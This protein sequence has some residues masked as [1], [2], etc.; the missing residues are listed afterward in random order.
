VILTAAAVAVPE[1][2]LSPGWVQVDGAAIA[3]VGAGPPPGRPDR[4]FTGTLAPGLVDIHVHGGGGQ[5]FMTGTQEAA[6]TV[7]A[8]HRRHGTTSMMASLV[9]DTIDELERIVTSLVPL[10]QA[11]ELLGIHLEGPWLSSAHCGAHDPSRIALPDRGDIDRLLDAGEGTIRMVTIAPEL[12]GG[13]AA[14]RHLAARGVT[15]ALGHS[16]ATFDQAWESFDAGVS[17]GTHVFNAMRRLHHRDPA[18]VLAIVQAKEVYAEL[19]ADGIHVHPALLCTVASAKPR[20]TV[21]VSDAMGAAGAADGR[22]VLGPTEVEVRDGVARLLDGGAIAGSTL[23]L[24]RAVSYCTR[25]AGIPLHAALHAAT[26]A[27]ASALDE[28]AVGALLPG[29]RADLLALT[30]TLEVA[31][32]MRR[33]AWLD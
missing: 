33:G 2:L 7:I 12:P 31:A 32:V 17:V 24:S 10:V 25:E 26:A 29:R 23:T 21:L 27:P 22:Y 18:A 5:S 20:H 1:R 8:T 28:E 6:R 9:S 14:V 11:G 15:V 4:H 30:P 3:A 13:T 19:V 16:D